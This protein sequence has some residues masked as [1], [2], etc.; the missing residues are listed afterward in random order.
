MFDVE[1]ILE[2][3]RLRRRLSFWRIA[4]ILVSIVALIGVGLVASGRN[5][6]DIGRPHVARITISGVITGDRP[7]LELIDRVSKSSTV[8]GVVLVIN[9]P[10]G[11]V[12]GSE[13]LHD[14][15]R[16]LVAAKPTVAFVDNL[17]ASGGYV[18]AIGTDHIVARANALVGSIGVIFQYPNA[19]KLLDTIGVQ[20]ETVRSSPLK[21]A[22][23]GLEPTSPEARAALERLVV[24]SF[25]WFKDLVRDRR[26]YDD[27]GL[28]KVADGRVFSGREA[29]GLKLID[30]I[31]T[32]RDAIAWMTVEKKVTANL[33]VLDWRPRAQRRGMFGLG[34]TL[35]TGLLEAAGLDGVARMMAQNAPVLELDGLLALWHPRVAP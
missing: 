4:A 25:A 1:A 17:A 8:Q 28:A 18:A 32:E 2:R 11:T 5:I 34:N 7:T 12:T 23:S 19:T 6:N 33:P 21:A 16:R 27:A 3:R 14:A 9:S 31:G 10:G 15:I 29:I 20:V 30:Q 26:M 35:L 22:P 13:A 24:D